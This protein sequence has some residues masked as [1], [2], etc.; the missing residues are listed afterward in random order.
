VIDRLR[1]R[2]L[3]KNPLG[4]IVI[5]TPGG[6]GYAVTAPLSTTLK[7]PPEGEETALFTRLVLREESAELFGFLT[8]L[9]R[10]AFDILTSVSR[11]GPKLAVTVLSS[12]DPP[13]LARALASQDLA[14]L[15]AVKGI[16]VKTAE[17][18]MVELKDKAKKLVDSATAASG[19]KEDGAPLPPVALFSDASSA[20]QNMGYT[21]AES[22]KALRGIAPPPEADYNA[23]LEHLLRES[24]KRLAAPGR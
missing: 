12:L 24:L 20:L 19:Q 15:A 2:I 14:R 13:E 3:A 10:D 1:G 18:I 5:D 7:L 21:R 16:G 17:R 23:S 9:E 4:S 6:V 11:V 8:A 22:E